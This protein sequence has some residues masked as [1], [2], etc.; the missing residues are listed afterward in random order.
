MEPVPLSDNPAVLGPG[1]TVHATLA[2]WARF[3]ALHLRAGRGEPKL[4]KPE[5]FTKLYQPGEGSDYAMGFI[6]VSR[7]WAQGKVLIHDGS[8]GLWYAVIWL[9]PEVD[10]AFLAVSNAGSQQAAGAADEAIAA[11]IGEYVSMT[12]SR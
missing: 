1:A 12:E 6:A 4:I 8:N 10:M 9:A 5:F 11:L 3:A 2:D 7:P